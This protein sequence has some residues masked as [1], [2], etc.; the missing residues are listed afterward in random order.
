[1]IKAEYTSTGSVHGYQTKEM[2]ILAGYSPKKAKA[3]QE[4]TI[5]Q[6]KRGSILEQKQL[7]RGSKTVRSNHKSKI[8]DASSL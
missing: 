4:K 7:L 5:K 6:S 2:M 8:L 1:M 3:K